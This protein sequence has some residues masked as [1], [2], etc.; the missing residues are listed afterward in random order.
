MSRTIPQIQSQI[1]A[2]VKADPIL[3]GLNSTSKRAIWLL[4]TYIFATATFLL[5]SLIDIFK[6]SVELTASMAAP[7]SAAWLQAQVL[8]FQYSATVPQI[9]QLINF[10]PAYPTVDT[11][12]QIISRTS[13]VTTVAGQ[14]LIKVATGNPPTALSTPQLDALQDYVNAIGATVSYVVTSTA[15]DELY[16]AADVYYQGQYSAIISQNVI[17][18]INNYLAA[19][20]FNGQLKVSDIELTIRSVTG[21][22]D[23]ILKNVIARTNSTPLASGTYLVQ[24]ETYISRTWN[25][26]SGYMVSETTSGGT[27]VDTLNFIA[28]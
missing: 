5:E 9:I 4:W 26:V 13:V 11:T 8:K 24:N 15:A 20:P 16:I 12:L 23:C 7:A 2:D 10:A 28:Q 3:S 25:T 18:A 1:I 22:N 19:L 21:I 6:T 17:L 14:T 27:L